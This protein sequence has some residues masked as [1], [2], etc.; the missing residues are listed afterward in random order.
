MEKA[1][2]GRWEHLSRLIG[3]GGAKL[4]QGLI[5]AV[6]RSGVAVGPDLRKKLVVPSSVSD[7]PL[8]A[9]YEKSLRR[10]GL[11]RP[12]TSSRCMPV[13]TADDNNGDVADTGASTCNG[14]GT[15][16][17]DSSEGSQWRG[18]PRGCPPS[19]ACMP[20]VNGFISRLM[21]VNQAPDYVRPGP[22]PILN[23]AKNTNTAVIIATLRSCQLTAYFGVHSEPRILKLLLKPVVFDTEND[24]W[25]RSKVLEPPS[26]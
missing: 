20:Y 24:Q 14:N 11:H 21:R 13:G 15:G 19:M 6:G 26:K 3:L 12:S 1:I 22:P 25:T 10:G 8:C 18:L 23:E 7:G 2:P 16:L 9:T 17:G 4:V 5:N